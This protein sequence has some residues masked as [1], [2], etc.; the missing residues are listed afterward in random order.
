MINQVRTLILTPCLLIPIHFRLRNLHSPTLHLPRLPFVH[1][2]RKCCRYGRFSKYGWKPDPLF[3]RPDHTE[4][5]RVFLYRELPSLPT[6][7]KEMN[8]A[9]LHPLAIGR[10]G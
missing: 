6:Y 7:I 3:T 10:T 5:S 9:L 1:R 4:A 2:F 8:H